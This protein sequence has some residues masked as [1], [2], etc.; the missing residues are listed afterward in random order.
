MILRVPSSLEPTAKRD[1]ESFIRDIANVTQR[2]IRP[3]IRRKRKIRE[4][5]KGYP[6]P[7]N[8]WTRTFDKDFICKDNFR[9][10]MHIDL[11][12]NRDAVGISMGYVPEF[13]EREIWKESPSD[14]GKLKTERVMLP[15]V[16][17]DFWGRITVR[18]GEDIIL[19][20]I[21]ELIYELSRRKFYFGIISFDRFQ[22][23]LGS[24]KVKML[25]GTLKTMQE[26]SELPKDEQYWLYSWS[27]SKNKIVPALG[28][29]SR[30]TGKKVPVYKVVLDNDK[31]IICTDSHPFLMRDGSYKQVKE[32]K[33]GD[34]LMPLYYRDRHI[35]P[36]TKAGREYEQIYQINAK[37]RKWKYTHREVFKD[38]NNIIDNDKT[39]VIHHVDFNHRNNEPCNLKSL[40]YKEHKVLHTNQ[41][42]EASLRYWTDEKKAEQSIRITKINKE[43]S[44]YNRKRHLE[45]WKNPEWRDSSIK[46]MSDSMKNKWTDPEYINQIMK[47]RFENIPERHCNYCD[48]EYKP[49]SIQQ[50]SCSRKCSRLFRLL[51]KDDT[52]ICTICNQSY[53]GKRSACSDAC[54]KI[55]K[56]EKLRNRKIINHKI[57]SIEFYGYEDVYDLEV[58]EHHNFGL[59]AGIFVHNSIDSIQILRSYGYRT[60]HQSIDRTA[61]YIVLDDNEMGFSKKSTEGNYNA[62]Q[63]TLRELIY[64]N[65]LWIPDSSKVGY[66]KDYFEDELFSAQEVPK[67]GKIDHPPGSTLD[68]EQSVCGTAFH[69]INNE[70]MYQLTKNEKSYSEF[71]D[72][73][74]KDAQAK[75]DTDLLSKNPLLGGSTDP[76]ELAKD[77]RYGL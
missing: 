39:K 1:L 27:H 74:Y 3:F 38:F 63:F 16:K 61:H 14:E 73:Y 8:P 6:N 35:N 44:E 20:E 71:Q 13:V 65:R 43:K 46:K 18:K 49:T 29:N 10:Y 2:G 76:R 28:Q 9:R 69:C 47:S 33:Q 77:N 11:G 30:I 70:K 64:D 75:L 48:L 60:A 54:L 24:T 4:C 68:V 58:P 26:L 31:E 59:E 67:S 5:L 7:F 52:L 45:L 56:R 23:L 36:Y 17:L 12:I 41:A 50:Y 62:A 57:K 32:L 37:T 55:K 42:I 21:R 51:H 15:I 53:K 25:N 22:C 66:D 34:S 19:G 40:T 72:A